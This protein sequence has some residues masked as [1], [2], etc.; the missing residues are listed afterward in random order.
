MTLRGEPRIDDARVR[1]IDEARAG[2]QETVDCPE[3]GSPTPP[4]AI[5]KWGNCRPCRTAQ[6]RRT[7]P[8]R[9]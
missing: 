2:S 1:E 6:S 8:L 4:L 5:V 7:E 3:C 9:W